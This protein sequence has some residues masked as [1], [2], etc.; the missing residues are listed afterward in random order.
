MHVPG[1]HV[2]RGKAY[3]SRCRC[4]LDEAQDKRL[5]EEEEY[6]L[7]EGDL[8]RDFVDLG[9]AIDLEGFANDDAGHEKL[10]ANG[11]KEEVA[12]PFAEFLA[13]EMFQDWLGEQ[14]D[15]CIDA[16]LFPED[17]YEAA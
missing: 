16:G 1:L 4:F 17:G 3:Y 15:L 6:E 14:V 11:L 13:S 2:I 10:V 12:A 9:E 8:R 5:K 7:P